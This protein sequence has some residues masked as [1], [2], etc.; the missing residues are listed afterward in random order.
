MFK[1]KNLC[2]LCSSKS[3]NIQYV[4]KS[5]S[6]DVETNN[7]IIVDDAEYSQCTNA[8]CNQTWISKTQEKYVDDI[9]AKRSFK[10]LIPSEI[11]LIRKCLP[12][13]T[14]KA[15]ADFMCLNE[16]AFVKWENGY[17]TP[18]RAYDLLL[19]LIAYSEEN[20]KFI[21]TLHDKNF[22]FEASDYHFIR[23]KV[24]H[25][26]LNTSTVN[27]SVSIDHIRAYSKATE[28][29]EKEIQSIDDNNAEAA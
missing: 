1:T 12:L 28:L 13:K 19:R 22:K 11:T 15:I 20:F 7:P 9:I 10:A 29:K 23:N 17:S 18:N 27:W 25:S 3:K 5:S 14:K 4:Y 24:L 6:L 16:K 21:Q 8:N 2:P 26:S